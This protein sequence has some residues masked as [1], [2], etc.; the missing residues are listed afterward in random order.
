ML[1][2]DVAAR[3]R[4]KRDVGVR[5]YEKERLDRESV[6]PPPRIHRAGARAAPIAD[7]NRAVIPV[8]ALMVVVSARIIGV[9]LT[10]EQ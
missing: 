3:R 4:F 1:N 8:D 9:C 7:A 5:R 10:L 2:H 6:L